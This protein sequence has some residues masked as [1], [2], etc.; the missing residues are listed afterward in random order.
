M[1][2]NIKYLLTP[3]G[4]R[5][6]A[7][8]VTKFATTCPF[9]SASADTVHP[10][11]VS[12]SILQRKAIENE[13]KDFQFL[14]DP[15]YKRYARFYDDSNDSDS[16]S[17][18]YNLS[19]D[20][21]SS[22]YKVKS[23]DVKSQPE[24]LQKSSPKSQDEAIDEA[25]K[26]LADIVGELEFQLGVESYRAAHYEDAAEHFKLST[27]YQHLGGIFNLA[28]CY[29]QGLGVKKNLKTAKQ[30]YEIASGLGHVKAMYNLGVFHAQ[31]LGTSRD[32]HRAKKYFSEAAKLGNRDASEA[33]KLLLPKPIILPV[34]EE[35]DELF[36]NNTSSKLGGIDNHKMMRIAVT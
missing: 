27:N 29:E 23:D 35:Y 22:E 10:S 5:S 16:S 32:F 21:T 26:Q 2:Q 34:I 31:G 9:R 19:N 8:S 17:K 12:S 7:D 28:I 24:N 20:K 25:V 11:G 3:L 15:E 14:I 1:H 30:L 18:P 36:F 33:I 6:L 4:Q 13:I